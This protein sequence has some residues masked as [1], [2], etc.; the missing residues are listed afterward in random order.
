MTIKK[1]QDIVAFEVRER[2]PLFVLGV[3]CIGGCLLQLKRE[4]FRDCI[5]VSDT[6]LP[7]FETLAY[8]L[9]HFDDLT[10]VVIRASSAFII[11]A[12]AEV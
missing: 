4:V 9:P 3:L 11:L 1:S 2:N 8:A 10:H 12:F 7:R 5:F 6:R